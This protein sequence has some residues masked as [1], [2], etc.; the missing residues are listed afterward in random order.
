M[1]YA[2][3]DNNKNLLN[4]YSSKLG[5]GIDEYISD[6]H[7]NSEFIN[8]L[9]SNDIIIVENVLSLGSWVEEIVDTI[10]KLSN[11]KINLYLIREDLQL[12]ASELSDISNGL[13][14]AHKI[15][16][17]LISLRSHKAIHER[18]AQG[19]SFGRPVNSFSSKKLDGK[20]DELKALLSKGMPL[21]DIAVELNVSRSTI[22]NYMKNNHKLLREW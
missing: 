17:S 9:S 18:I 20:I 11:L 6:S 4:D 10:S 8:R 5:L 21:T 7:I 13:L 14:I 12:K 19:H 1:I 15:H 16:R 3:V 2:L 22:Y